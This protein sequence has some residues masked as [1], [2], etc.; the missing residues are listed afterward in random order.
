MD[1]LDTLPEPNETSEEA[2]GKM[3]MSLTEHQQHVSRRQ[4]H[5]G[6][7]MVAVHLLVERQIELL[8][9]LLGADPQPTVAAITD[10]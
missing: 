4:D 3:I 7:E 1:Q 2:L 5:I 9:R 6:E 10:G 8:D